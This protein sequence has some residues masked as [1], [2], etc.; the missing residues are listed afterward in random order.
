MARIELLHGEITEVV[1]AGCFTVYNTLGYGFQESVYRNALA[2]ELA[3]RGLRVQR[4]VP[5]EVPYRG[6]RVGTFRVDLFVEDKVMVEAKTQTAL[7]EVD[8]KQLTNYL[9][10]TAIEVG[11]LFN[12]GPKPKLQRM[13][14]TNDMKPLRA[15]SAG[16]V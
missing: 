14:L 13:V 4:E 1:I 10:A 5:V 12:F 16:S 15:V 8:S 3:F 9:S 11:L 6:V 7:T 2:V